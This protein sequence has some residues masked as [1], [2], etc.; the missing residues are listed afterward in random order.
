MKTTPAT[1]EQNETEKK[2]NSAKNLFLVPP[3]AVFLL[4]Q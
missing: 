4:P 1:T 3:L 2:N